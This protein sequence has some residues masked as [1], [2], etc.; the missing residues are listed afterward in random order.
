M[1]YTTT[2]LHEFTQ[3]KC[4][5][6]A[7]NIKIKLNYGVQNKPLPAVRHV[8]ICILHDIGEMRGH[9]QKQGKAERLSP[10]TPQ[11]KLMTCTCYVVF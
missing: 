11:K 1:G 2:I 8:T 5:N 6:S 4:I 10:P 9:W 3:L 7:L